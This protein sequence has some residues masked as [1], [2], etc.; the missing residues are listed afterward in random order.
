MEPREEREILLTHA[1]DANFHRVLGVPILAGRA[2][3]EAE[4]RDSARVAIL[5]QRPAKQLF[6]NASP[7]GR[8]FRYGP[9]AEW[10]TVVGVAAEIDPNGRDVTYR[11]LQV[12]HPGRSR[13]GAF[14][15]RVSPGSDP[16]AVLDRIRQ[17]L[18][19]EA[20]DVLIPVATTARGLMWERAARERFT[21]ALLATFGLLAFVLAIVGLYGVVSS[22]VGQRT[23]EIGI[24][25]SLGA[26]R[27]DVRRLVLGEGAGATALGIVAGA[28]LAWAGLQIL[29]SQIF[30]LNS[31]GMAGSY[32]TA[33]ALLS[34]ASLAACWVPAQR[35]ASLDPVR[36]MRED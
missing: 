24:R 4:V 25:V 19:T 22:L 32:G 7:L 5:A 20:P 18:R 11:E 12:Y 36:A 3:T 16:D 13:G 23:R 1:V 21:T 26:D 17:A 6:G 15:I 14:V 34:L 29:S 2:F 33:A 10:Y 27:G 8:R 9:A 30:G 28:V 31:G 35:A